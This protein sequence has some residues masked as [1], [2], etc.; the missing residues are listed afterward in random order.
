[1]LDVLSLQISLISGLVFV[2][3]LCIKL[4]RAFSAYPDG[5]LTL[6]HIVFTELRIPM[7]PTESSVLDLWCRFYGIKEIYN[8]KQFTISMRFKFDYLFERTLNI[9][10][11]YEN[12]SQI[13]TVI[14]KLLKSMPGIPANPNHMS[15]IIKEYSV[16]EEDYSNNI[17]IFEITKEMLYMN[18]KNDFLQN[19]I[20]YNADLLFYGSITVLVIIAIMLLPI[21][22]KFR[23]FKKMHY[24]EQ[25][26]AFGQFVPIIHMA[27]AISPIVDNKIYQAITRNILLLKIAAML[28]FMSF[29]YYML[30]KIISIKVHI[31]PENMISIIIK[32]FTYLHFVGFM[33]Y[34]WIMMYIN[35]FTQQTLTRQNVIHF[36]FAT[37][38]FIIAL[39]LEKITDLFIN[40]YI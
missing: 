32:S 28:Y 24:F 34:L 8:D 36:T 1:M 13:L 17:I 18:K 27:I 4:F 23:V 15:Q 3:L 39:V 22:Y 33:H 40:P 10:K 26:R 7:F 37:A 12:R 21:F 2:F 11:H 5:K 30:Y 9:C 29:D 20:H 14:L 31:R 19:W 16:T 38:F 6:D 35:L 25:Y